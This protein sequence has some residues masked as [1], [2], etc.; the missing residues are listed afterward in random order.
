MNTIG[1]RIKNQRKKI[2]LPR[3]SLADALGIAYESVRQWEVEIAQPRP[4]LYERLSEALECDITWLVTGYIGVLSQ[5]GLPPISNTATDE[6][7]AHINQLPLS[8]Q[9]KIMEDIAQRIREYH[10]KDTGFSDNI[11]S[12][13]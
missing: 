2:N 1:E 4:Q 12:K 9:T 8:E 3:Q 11:Y 10:N 6:L 5:T 13:D 7:K